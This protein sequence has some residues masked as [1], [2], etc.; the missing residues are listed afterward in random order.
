LIGITRAYWVGLFGSPVSH[1]LNPQIFFEW[2]FKGRCDSQ[3]LERAINLFVSYSPTWRAVITPNGTMR[4]LRD[5]P[6]YRISNVYE[7]DAQN[8]EQHKLEVRKQMISNGPNPHKWPLFEWRITHQSP[9]QSM[10]HMCVSLFIMD[11]ISDLTMRRHISMLYRD[12]DAFIHQPSLSYRDYCV[13]LSKADGIIVNEKHKRSLAHWR[14]HVKTL[15]P[16]PELPMIPKAKG[17]TSD[18]IFHHVGGL[19]TPIQYK[20]FKKNSC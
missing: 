1:P 18:N 8:F 4:V 13:S 5:A 12:P 7:V 3:R 9:N 20:Q 17:Y 16:P 6:E 14:E 11:G 19:L 15:P 2:K 10:L